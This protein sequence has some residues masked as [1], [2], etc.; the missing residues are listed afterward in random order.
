MVIDTC[1]LLKSFKGY[2][3]STKYDENIPSPPKL[4]PIMN[5]STN[6]NTSILYSFMSLGYLYDMLDVHKRVKKKRQVISNKGL[7]I[8]T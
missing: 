6:A 4:P 5:T 2:T 7:Q 3:N 1:W 8:F